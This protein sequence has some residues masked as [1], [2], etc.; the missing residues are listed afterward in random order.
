M[1]FP[2]MLKN[3][4]KKNL[5]KVDCVL[6]V[7]SKKLEKNKQCLVYIFF[8]TINRKCILTVYIFWQC[9][10]IINQFHFSMKNKSKL[11]RSLTRWK[12]EKTDLQGWNKSKK[13]PTMMQINPQKKIHSDLVIKQ[14]ILLVFISFNLVLL[15]N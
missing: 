8:C 5:K 2:L 7:L 9:A 1:Y 4:E 6:R 13:N 10:D 11:K 3:K 15:L 12:S 14:V